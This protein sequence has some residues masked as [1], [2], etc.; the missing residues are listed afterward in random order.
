MNKDRDTDSRRIR[1]ETWA[2]E[3]TKAET[4]LL[5][6]SGKIQVL[7]SCKF[8][9]SAGNQ[10]KALSDLQG[11]SLIAYLAFSPRFPSTLLPAPEPDKQK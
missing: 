8:E 11:D 7:T 4:G 2:R 5:A 1:A 3:D 10:S 6:V 9:K